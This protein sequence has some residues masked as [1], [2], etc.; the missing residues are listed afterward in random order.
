[1]FE[2]S[3]TAGRLCL[4]MVRKLARRSPCIGDVAASGEPLGCYA[5]PV[6]AGLARALVILA[7]T[8]ASGL[9]LAPP[10]HAGMTTDETDL[11]GVISAL[12]AGDAPEACIRMGRLAQAPPSLE[13]LAALGQVADAFEAAGFHICLH[14]PGASMQAVS[15]PQPPRGLSPLAQRVAAPAPR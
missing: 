15:L 13:L 6:R 10:G 7:Q 8:R 3:W 11:L 14:D 4:H 12:Q 5:G 1:M 2:H 9:R